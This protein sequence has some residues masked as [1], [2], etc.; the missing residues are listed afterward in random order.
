MG[1]VVTENQDEAR[2]TRLAAGRDG[3]QVQTKDDEVKKEEEEADEQY[4]QDRI[5]CGCDVNKKDGTY[6]CS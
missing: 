2:R 1:S 3:D 6:P 5:S 4:E